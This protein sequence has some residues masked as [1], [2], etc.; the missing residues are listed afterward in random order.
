MKQLFLSNFVFDFPWRLNYNWSGG[1]LNAKYAFA[2]LVLSTPNFCTIRLVSILSK[3]WGLGSVEVIANSKLISIEQRV[4]QKD[5][6]QKS[7]LPKWGQNVIAILGKL[8]A[9]LPNRCNNIA[10]SLK[11]RC[12]RWWGGRGCKPN[13]KNF[14]LSTIWAKS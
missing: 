10:L 1:N 3:K 9:S 5:Y 13:P 8:C 11:Q 4:E 7:N 6:A 2:V 12:R 14:D